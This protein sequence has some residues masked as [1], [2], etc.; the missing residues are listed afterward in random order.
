MV[1]FKDEELVNFSGLI[2]TTIQVSKPD[3]EGRVRFTEEDTNAEDNNKATFL[4]DI[5]EVTPGVFTATEVDTEKAAS[6]ANENNH[7]SLF[8]THG[9][10]VEPGGMLK[11]FSEE[12]LKYFEEKGFY[13]IPVIW[14]SGGEYYK[15]LIDRGN[16]EKAAK[17]LKSLTEIIDNKTFP[18]KSL[19]CH[20]MG[21][22]LVFHS[23][24]IKS[25]NAPE[26]AD[27]QF[28]NIF[29]VA[30]DVQADIFTELPKDNTLFDCKHMQE[31]AKNMKKMLAT[32]ED[33]NPIGKIYVLYRSNDKAL[34]AS[35]YFNLEGKR[36]GLKGAD[37][38]SA[39][40]KGIVMNVDTIKFKYDEDGLL[41]GLFRT[42]HGYQYEKWAIDF[43]SSPSV[44][45]EDGL[46]AEPA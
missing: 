15:Y 8:C 25:K 13:P 41:G 35:P 4:K 29:M 34:K 14:A 24:D 1:L 30:A 36:L 22:H 9:F 3:N 27:A 42:K 23:G 33:N 43:Y 28:E 37:A 21:N 39:E 45:K 46:M 19:L 32:D 31:K 7:T 26:V 11:E 17:I 5:K 16:A 40:F 44:E 18:K 20:S 38:V 12:K 2:L 10:N 6:I